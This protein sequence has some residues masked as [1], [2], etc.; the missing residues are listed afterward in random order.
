VAGCCVCGNE[1]LGSIE[2]GDFMAAE[3]MLVSQ[4]GLF[5]TELVI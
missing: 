3:E 4:E 2:C 1:H 5:Y